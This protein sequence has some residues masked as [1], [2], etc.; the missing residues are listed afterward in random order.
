MVRHIVIWNH[1]DGLSET[2]RGENAKKLKAELENL[3]NL[4]GGIVDIKVYSDALPSSN[5]AILLDVLFENPEALAAYTI[6]PEHV[7]AGQFVR[8]VTKDRACMDF[9]VE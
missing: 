6:H 1:A 2:E 9:V 5:R 3:K 4:I 8:A 7:R